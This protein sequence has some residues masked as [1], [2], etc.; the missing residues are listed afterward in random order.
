MYDNFFNT[1]IV[2]VYVPSI[3]YSSKLSSMSKLKC[4]VLISLKFEFELVSTI[5]LL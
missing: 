1:R 2:N 3:I 5:L 4:T